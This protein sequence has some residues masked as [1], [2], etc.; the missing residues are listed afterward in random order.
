M[1]LIGYEPDQANELAIDI[2]DKRLLSLQKSSDM[3]NVTI[4]VRAP[5]KKVGDLFVTMIIF[6]P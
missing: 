1:S 3:H 6:N 2:D 4:C 5:T